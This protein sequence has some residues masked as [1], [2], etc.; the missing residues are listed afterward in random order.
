MAYLRKHILLS[1]FSFLFTAT[2]LF[3]QHI[4]LDEKAHNLDKTG[5]TLL[6]YLH[7][8]GCPYCERLEEFTF[9]DGDVE[10]Y[11]ANNYDFESFNVSITKDRV[12]YNGKSMTNKEFSNIFGYGF[13][14]VVIFMDSKKHIIYTSLGYVEDRIFLATL[15]YVT[16]KAYKKMSFDEYKKHIHFKDEEE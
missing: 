9:D 13:Y 1:M 7:K 4:N 8:T 15:Q 14:P 5:K 11:I 16:T 2:Q 3:S 6:I 12:V 10:Q